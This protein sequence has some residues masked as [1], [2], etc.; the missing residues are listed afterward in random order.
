[1][2]DGEA[3]TAQFLRAFSV[4]RETALD[5]A[6]GRDARIPRARAVVAGSA[7]G[8]A[9]ALAGGGVSGAGFPRF[10]QEKRGLTLDEAGVK[11]GAAHI[12]RARI[13]GHGHVDSD[14]GDHAVAEDERAF[15]NDLAGRDDDAS[16]NERV[17][18]RAGV[19]QAFERRGR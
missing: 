18:T 19:A 9:A 12:P 13:G 14:R 16:A 6:L 5:A 15:F 7:R 3:K 10:G 11:R 2:G 1:M 8:A 17:H 4:G